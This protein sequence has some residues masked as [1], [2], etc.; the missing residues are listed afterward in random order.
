MTALVQSV[1][2]I[3]SG[4]GFNPT[5]IVRRLAPLACLIAVISVVPEGWTGA[6]D[7]LSE[8]YLAVSVY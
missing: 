4:I 2:Q 8:A 7:A 3:G 1:R 6:L 5:P